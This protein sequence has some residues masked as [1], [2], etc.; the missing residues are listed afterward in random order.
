MQKKDLGLVILVA[1]A[2]FLCW[3]D[4]RGGMHVMPPSGGV[5]LAQMMPAAQSPGGQLPD[6]LVKPFLPQEEPLD[7]PKDW[8][9]GK[10]TGEKGQPVLELRRS[11]QT[12]NAQAVD[13]TL[14]GRSFVGDRVWKQVSF[15]IGEHDWY[16]L[17]LDKDG[18]AL[19][20]TQSLRRWDRILPTVSGDPGAGR[21]M[22]ARLRKQ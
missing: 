12:G 8:W 20:Y 22:I 5:A 19:L 6:W 13:G 18:S 1:G 17:V 9:L 15:L 16:N 3:A 10:W 11:R 14:D 7:A 21:R 4:R 2:A